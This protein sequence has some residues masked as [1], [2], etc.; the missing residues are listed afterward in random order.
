MQIGN[1]QSPVPPHD[2]ALS[3]RLNGQ[4]VREKFR[5]RFYNGDDSYIVLE[6]KSKFNQLCGKES[7][8]ITKEQVLLLSQG[9][10][11]WLIQTGHPLCHELYAKMR[12]QLLRPSVIVDYTRKAFVY[13]PGNV[14]VTL[15]YD[16]R[17]GL[18]ATDL[19]VKRG[20]IPADMRGPIIMEVKYD[21]YLPEIIRM[22]VQI[23]ERHTSSF[24]KY[25]ACRLTNY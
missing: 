6:K 10:Y 12:Y 24:S 13:P 8:R 3:E 2:K 16:V 7:T 23:P 21:A 20:T 17:T 14:R 9:N 1:Q 19:F 15:D 5:I 22:A 4:E 11:E 25:A 18:S